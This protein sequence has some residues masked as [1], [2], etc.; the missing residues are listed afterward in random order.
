MVTRV[1]ELKEE[2]SVVGQEDQP[3]AVGI[4]AAHGPQ[5]RVAADVH[6]FSYQSPGMGVRA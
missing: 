3:I 6:K 5:H 2:I 1:R 4:Q